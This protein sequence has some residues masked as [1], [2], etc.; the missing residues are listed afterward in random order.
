MVDCSGDYYKQK[1]GLFFGYFEKLLNYNNG[2]PLRGMF[3]D[4]SDWLNNVYRPIHTERF[5]Q[6]LWQEVRFRN[7]QTFRISFVIA[8][9]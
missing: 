4:V 1:F 7:I 2:K 3:T 5:P 9:R 6:N 8:P